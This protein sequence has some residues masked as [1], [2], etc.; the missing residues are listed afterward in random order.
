MGSGEGGIQAKDLESTKTLIL[1]A[2]IENDGR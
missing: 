2:N 1:Q